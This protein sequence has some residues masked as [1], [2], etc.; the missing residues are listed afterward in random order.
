MDGSGI[1]LH[2]VFSLG[3]G[4]TLILEDS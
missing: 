2:Q 1:S 4:Q 3:Q